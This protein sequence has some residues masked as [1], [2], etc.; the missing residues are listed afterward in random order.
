MKSTDKFY[1]EYKNALIDV[2]KNDKK[3]IDYCIKKTSRVI[4]VNGLLFTT[5][6]P[7]IK[8]RFC[9]GYDCS[10]DN[11]SFDNANEMAQHARTNE[12]YFI[13]QNLKQFDD[14]I[15]N[16]KDDN[17]IK[18]YLKS[19]AYYSQSKDNPLKAVC[20]ERFSRWLDHNNDDKQQLT[21]EMITAYIEA[22]KLDRIDFKK[23]L[24][25]YLK[26]YGL[27]KIHSWSYWRD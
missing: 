16:L 9:F 3:M 2:W 27:S 10:V 26:K 13:D 15:K 4:K 21:D 18:Y 19:G 5:D 12:Q 6:K 17:I 14:E 7:T 22:L 23:R 8:T 11:E 25:T 24:D 1:N 20:Y